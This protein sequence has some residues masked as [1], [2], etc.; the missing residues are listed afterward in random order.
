MM[1]S[2]Y[3]KSKAIDF[4]KGDLMNKNIEIY[5]YDSKGNKID[6][7]LMV[8]KIKVV[9]DLVKKYIKEQST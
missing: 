6:P 5:N 1:S 8:I 7:N 2:S 3:S 9:Y 4:N